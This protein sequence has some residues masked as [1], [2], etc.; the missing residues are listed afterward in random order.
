M[1][2]G[3]PRGPRARGGGSERGPWSAARAP[4]QP[5][6]DRGLRWPVSP[7]R[8]RRGRV[9]GP[10]KAAARVAGPEFRPL[11][12]G[13]AK[14]LLSG[15]SFVQAAGRALGPFATCLGPPCTRDPTHADRREPGPGEVLSTQAAKVGVFHQPE[16]VKFENRLLVKKL[17]RLIEQLLWRGSSS[18]L[19][20]L[21][22]CPKLPWDFR[23]F[24]L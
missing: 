5:C 22:D 13:T 11:L 15:R 12:D 6:C 19:S 2:G 1:R 23:V 24:V 9:S 8:G 4:A 3:S 16:R 17:R 14:A 7:G 18:C 21:S 10:H 20:Y